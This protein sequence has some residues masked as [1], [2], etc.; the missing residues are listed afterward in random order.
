MKMD[1]SLHEH[2]RAALSEMAQDVTAENKGAIYYW[3]GIHSEHM[4]D[5][6]QAAVYYDKASSAYHK[7]GYA[8]RESRCHCNLGSAKMRMGDPTGMAEFET[9]VKLDPRNG[10]AHINI[11]R[12]YYRAGHPGDAQ[13]ERALEAFADAIVADPQ[14]YWPIVIASLRQIG[15]TWSEDL[16]EIT[17]RVERKQRAAGSG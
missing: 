13:H 3:L 9:A 4:R 11:G 14:T 12:A 8:R 6:K 1:P 17:R 15:Y 2:A 7:L 5:W 16:E 10:T